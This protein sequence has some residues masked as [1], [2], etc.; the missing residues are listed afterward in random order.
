MTARHIALVIPPSA[1]P[2]GGQID[3]GPHLRPP[4]D[5]L[6]HGGYG[7]QRSDRPPLS[8]S[9]MTPAYDD[10]PAMNSRNLSP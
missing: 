6:A 4:P 3:C 9:L 10:P 1:V 8:A 2:V 5:A 7:P